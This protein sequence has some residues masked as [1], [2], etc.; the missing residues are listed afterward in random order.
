[1]SKCNTNMSKPR[2]VHIAAIAYR[3]NEFMLHI[4]IRKEIDRHH[5]LHNT[6]NLA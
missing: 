5:L 4:T 2:H 1:M 3:W 6:H